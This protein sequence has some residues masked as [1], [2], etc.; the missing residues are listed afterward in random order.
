MLRSY[1]YLPHPPNRSQVFCA[2]RAAAEKHAVAAALARAT[3]QT[4][5]E[6][7]RTGLLSVHGAVRVRRGTVV[8]AAASAASAAARGGNAQV[9]MGV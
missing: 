2:R 5:V 1:P 3:K 6:A 7:L 9:R 4:A 8:V